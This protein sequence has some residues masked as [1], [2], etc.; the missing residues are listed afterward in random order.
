VM[1][2]Q[3]RKQISLLGQMWRGTVGDLHAQK[4]SSPI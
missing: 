3:L 1:G 4:D 2:L